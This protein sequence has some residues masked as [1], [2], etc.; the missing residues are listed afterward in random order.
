MSVS[1]V[2]R[3]ETNNIVADTLQRLASVA[4]S[5]DSINEHEAKKRIVARINDLVALAPE[6]KPSSGTASLSTLDLA[7]QLLDRL[8]AAGYRGLSVEGLVRRLQ[9][10]AVGS[11]H[12]A[13]ASPEKAKP[14]GEQFYVDEL[15]ASMG[16]NPANVFIVRVPL[17]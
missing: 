16:V 13:H 1:C 2:S 11:T 8:P 17:Q 7:K 14:A 5:L 15:A 4:L 3:A 9:A 6:P 10:A 12:E